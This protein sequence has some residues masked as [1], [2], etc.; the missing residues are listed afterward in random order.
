MTYTIS[1]RDIETEAG[2]T[3]QF[4]GLSRRKS[5]IIEA[6]YI[7]TDKNKD[8]LDSKKTKVWLKQFLPK[9]PEEAQRVKNDFHKLYCNKIR[10]EKDRKAHDAAYDEYVMS[11]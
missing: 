7:L 3:S 2:W 6:S 5:L 10:T 11:L 4:Y 8:H 1:R 9:T